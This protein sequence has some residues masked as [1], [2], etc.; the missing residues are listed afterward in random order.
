MER[1]LNSLFARYRQTIQEMSSNFDSHEFIAR[2]AQENQ[3]EYIGAL[4]AYR[5]SRTPFKVVHGVLARHLNAFSDLVMPNGGT[6]S[7]DIF[8]DA[9]S[10]MKWRKVR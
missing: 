10:C 8:G 5:Q 7:N 4:A 9:C 6:I 1:I 3:N 2:L